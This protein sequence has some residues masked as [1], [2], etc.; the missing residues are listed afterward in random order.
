[1]KPPEFD[2]AAAHRY[3]AA[4]CFNR[5]WE[6][7]DKEHRTPDDERLMIALSLA[8]VYHWTQRPDCS[9]RT[10][11]I[12]YWQVSRVYALLGNAA[13]S[14]AY[15]QLALQ[16]SQGEPP[17]YSGF[18]YEALARAEALTGSRVKVTEYIALAR[19]L[20]AQVTDKDDRNSLLKDLDSI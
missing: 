10:M 11:S 9:D 13:E 15:A 1:M 16:F 5:A 20:A 18:A 12:G 17:F 2:V 8:S 3:F 7:I 14:R 19:Q 4:N 6:L